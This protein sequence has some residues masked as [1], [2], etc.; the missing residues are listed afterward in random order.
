M[1][2]AIICL[3]AYNRGSWA[4]RFSAGMQKKFDKFIQLQDAYLRKMSD[5]V[6]EDGSTPNEIYWHHVGVTLAQFD[7]ILD[8]INHHRSKDDQVGRLHHHH[9]ALSPLYDCHFTLSFALPLSDY[10]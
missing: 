7:G 10:A 4:N 6:G 8:G 9:P 1:R 3:V 5:N 2:L